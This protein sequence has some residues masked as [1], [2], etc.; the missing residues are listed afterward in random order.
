MKGE[1]RHRAREV[2]LQ[3]LFA[4]DLQERSRRD[5]SEAAAL[6]ARRDEAGA[7]SE[8]SEG[9][10][11]RSAGNLSAED[12]ESAF[13]AVA[14]HF[15]LPHAAEEFARELVSGTVEARYLVDRLI[16]DHARNWRVERMAVV[17]RNVL[18]LAAYELARTDTATAVVLDEAVELARRFGGDPSPAFVNGVLDALAASIRVEAG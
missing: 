1:A 4:L 15:E 7:A 14:A 13:A 16:S 17:D 10:A 2:A 8:P 5:A 11:A 6:E 3:V 12:A 18:R 9:E